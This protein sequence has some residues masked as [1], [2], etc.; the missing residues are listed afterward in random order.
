[1]RELVKIATGTEYI[2]D[3]QMY[4]F[5]GVQPSSFYWTSTSVGSIHGYAWSVYMVTGH[6]FG[7]DKSN[8]IYVWPVRG[9]F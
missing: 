9:P 1:M 6:V 7:E 2:R 5:V 8:D 3:N 4:F